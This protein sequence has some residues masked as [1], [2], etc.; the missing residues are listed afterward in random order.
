M[1]RR[2]SNRKKFPFKKGWGRIN[3]ELGCLMNF[4]GRQGINLFKIH[5]VGNK[6]R[7]WN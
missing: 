7:I 1:Q 3:L 4:W 2:G 5:G 6:I